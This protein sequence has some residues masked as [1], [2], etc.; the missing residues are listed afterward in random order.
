MLIIITN[1]Q[2]KPSS[3]AAVR[4]GFKNDHSSAAR[5]RDTKYYLSNLKYKYL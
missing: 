2:I 1:E 5:Y 3:A 4:I